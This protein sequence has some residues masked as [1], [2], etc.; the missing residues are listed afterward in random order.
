VRQ[1]LF[2]VNAERGE[3]LSYSLTCPAPMT[4]F[5]LENASGI[6]ILPG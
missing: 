4:S 2:A 5:A 3:A 1:S 6:L